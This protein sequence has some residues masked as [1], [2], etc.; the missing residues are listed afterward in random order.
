MRSSITPEGSPRVSFEIRGSLF[1]CSAVHPVPWPR[2]PAATFPQPSLSIVHYPLSIIQL[3]GHRPAVII[4]K[5]RRPPAGDAGHGQAS[6]DLPQG[7][8]PKG[9][10]PDS[11]P[12]GRQPQP[13]GLAPPPRHPTRPAPAAR[14]EMPASH[15]GVENLIIQSGPTDAGNP[16]T[17]RNRKFRQLDIHTSFI[18]SWQNKHLQHFATLTHSPKIP[19]ISP[20]S[21]PP[22]HPG[23]RP[24]V[25]P[26]LP[27]LL[28]SRSL[29]AKFRQILTTD[30]R[31]I[32]YSILENKHLRRLSPLTHPME[33][34][35]VPAAAPGGK[36]PSAPSFK[37]LRRSMFY[38]SAVLPLS[39][40]PSLPLSSLS[41]QLPPPGTP[42]APVQATRKNAFV[43]FVSSVCRFPDWI[44]PK[45]LP[46]PC[47]APC[48]TCA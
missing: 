10:H 44:I 28:V 14:V 23:A 33:S 2:C 24:G 6:L 13:Q 30:I 9:R 11:S 29:P 21:A 41:L 15:A 32:F 36:T 4:M 38:C 40:S 37:H 25:S 34:T 45:V 5:A 16:P 43:T 39:P 12:V 8:V 3:T 47:M 26:C 22:Q 17:R 42:P 31:Y 35:P 1:Y 19:P 48:S 18:I 20:G 46:R 27:L 7:P